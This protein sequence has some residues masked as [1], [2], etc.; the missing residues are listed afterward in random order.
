MKPKIVQE[1][2]LQLKMN[3]SLIQS[4]Q[5]LQFTGMEVVE[6]IQEM[7]KENPLIEDVSYDYELES[8]KQAG[9]TQ[10]AIGEINQKEESMYDQLKNQ[11]YTI[12]V[13]E[14]LRPAVLFGIDSLNEDGYLELDLETWK[15]QCA[16]SYEQAEEAL[17]WIQSL[18]PA[19]IGAR[20]LKECILLQLADAHT[21][22]EEL[23]EDHLE[24]LA[25]EDISAIGEHF[26]ISETEASEIVQQI[27]A[28]HPKP[29][30]LLSVKKTEYIIP[31]AYIYEDN[32]KWKIQFYKWH[33][34]VIEI[35]DAYKN[36]QPDEQE[37]A[38]Y[39]KEKYQQLN[40]LKQAVQFRGNTLERV[41]ETIV[42]KQQLYFAH[43]AF[44]LQPLTLKDLAAE[45][46]M[47]I[48]TI[49][50]AITNKYVQTKHGV[51]PLKFFLQSGV[52]QKN[53]Q[54]TASFV[55]KQ[56]IGELIKNE[57]KQKPLSD[58]AIK[59]R[60]QEEFGITVARRTVVKY[61]EQLGL[62]ASTKRK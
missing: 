39:L 23:L 49:S 35:S 7:A 21:L 54:Q 25:D 48:S 12:H 29:G 51:I 46:D 1:Q 9:E 15:E 53:G 28:C 55:I 41:I 44:M 10:P 2:K 8:F 56:L 38:N 27:K 11:L 32:G 52:K 22:A 61:R 57:D 50:R 17:G 59:I 13:P 26:Q 34:P 6:Y 14:N 62:P 3:Q 19:G 31:E 20:S 37:A 60:L 42:Q 18:E 30:H 24:W 43:G 58:Q 4:I 40:W 36:F 16:I 45:L 5:L 33:S 47:H